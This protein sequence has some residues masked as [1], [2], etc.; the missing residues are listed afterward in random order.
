M[1]TLFLQV[2]GWPLIEGKDWDPQ[3]FTTPQKM[4]L[5]IRKLINNATDDIFNTRK[6]AQDNKLV[7]CKAFCVL[8]VL[9][10]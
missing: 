5:D 10:F 2:G 7:G 6:D 4:I 8:C 3:S 1:R 9:E